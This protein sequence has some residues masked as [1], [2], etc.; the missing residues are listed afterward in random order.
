V[1]SRESGGRKS[2]SKY[3]RVLFQSFCKEIRETAA[4]G[5]EVESQEIFLMLNILYHVHMVMGVSLSC[6]KT[7]DTIYQVQCPRLISA[8]LTS[9]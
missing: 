9:L 8:F 6:L 5:E 4:D 7:S 1:N 2:D 3:R